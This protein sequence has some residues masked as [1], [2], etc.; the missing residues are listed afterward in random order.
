MKKYLDDRAVL[1]TAICLLGVALGGPGRFPWLHTI[2]YVGTA[3][4][5]IVAVLRVRNQPE[6]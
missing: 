3:S 1:V 5:F 6:A 4:A 2:A